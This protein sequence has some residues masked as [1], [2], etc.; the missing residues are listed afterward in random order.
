[1][2][3]NNIQCIYILYKAKKAAMHK[4]RKSR[5]CKIIKFKSFG[6]THTNIYT[7]VQ[8]TKYSKTST[9]WVLEMKIALHKKSYQKPIFEPYLYLNPSFSISLSKGWIQRS[10]CHTIPPGPFLGSSLSGVLL[11]H[12]LLSNL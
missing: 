12:G 9:N 10:F 8:F 1:M 6:N 2:I 4:D 7:I 5:E 11:V 3:F